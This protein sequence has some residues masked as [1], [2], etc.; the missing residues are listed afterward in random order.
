MTDVVSPA[1][2]D[3][4]MQRAARNRAVLEALSAMVSALDEIATTPPAGLREAVLEVTGYHPTPDRPTPPAALLAQALAGMLPDDFEGLD[5]YVRSLGAAP[6]EGVLCT[7][8][9]AHESGLRWVLFEETGVTIHGEFFLRGS[10]ATLEDHPAWLDAYERLPESAR[11]RGG[12]FD[13][14]P[15]GGDGIFV[16]LD[17]S[18]GSLYLVAEGGHCA[19]RLT[20][21]PEGY[22]HALAACGGLIGWQWLYIDPQGRN[23]AE[24]CAWWAR[25]AE[26]MV[27]LLPAFAP[28]LAPMIARAKARGSAGARDDSP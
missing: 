25:S 11:T 2:S 14:H 15:S 6:T 5:A 12:L 18:D 4:A 1:A 21:D 10:V 3:A 26:H 24:T 17:P 9:M 7:Y 8:G 20:L 13:A 23:A 22:L 28:T 16:V 27:R 19:E